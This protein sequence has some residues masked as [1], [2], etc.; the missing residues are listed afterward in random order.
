[1]TENGSVQS[2]VFT[3][4]ALMVCGAC[5]WAAV[6]RMWILIGSSWQEVNTAFQDEKSF[7][8]ME[9]FVVLFWKLWWTSG[10]WTGPPCR[11][12]KDSKTPEI[13]FTFCVSNWRHPDLPVW[14]ECRIIA[15][16][17]RWPGLTFACWRLTDNF[18][19]LRADMSA[20]DHSPDVSRHAASR[21]DLSPQ[22]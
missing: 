9:P 22:K 2:S 14:V 19:Q 6:T 12:N 4:E 7:H 15:S 18:L 13:L 5:V 1:M 10:L 8:Q 3:T 11:V 16:V 20:W 21:T 17:L